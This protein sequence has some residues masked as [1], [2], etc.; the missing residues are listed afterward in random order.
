MY[1]RGAR[2]WRTQLS[3][4]YHVQAPFPHLQ[5]RS[6][7]ILS[8]PFLSICLWFYQNKTKQKQKAT[9]NSEFVLL[10]LSPR[11]KCDGNN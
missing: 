11:D 7:T 4:H 1:Y 5:G 3:V 10:T 9:R 2:Q 8:L 6:I